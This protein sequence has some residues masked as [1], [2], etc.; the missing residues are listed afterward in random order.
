LL[1]ARPLISFRPMQ[2]TIATLAALA[3][4]TCA[5]SVLA[6]TWRAPTPTAAPSAQP[7][8]Y[9]PLPAPS[10]QIVWLRDG[11]TLRGYVVESV[12]NDHLTVRLD[13]GAFDR[14][15]WGDVVRVEPAVGAQPSAPSPVAAPPAGAVHV[16]LRANRRGAVL[17]RRVG[18]IG[19]LDDDGQT[20]GN[21]SLWERVCASPCE[22]DLAPGD[23]YRVAGEGAHPSR[24]F[25]LDPNRT[26]VR[27]DADVGS[28][29]ALSL[30]KG[31]VSTGIGLLALGT[32]M[33]VVPAPGGDDPSTD[34][35][36][37]TL[38]TVGYAAV[39]SGAV[40]TLVGLPLWIANATT[41][42]TDVGRTVGSL[43]AP[44]S[45][46]GIVVGARG[47]IF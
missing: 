21:A 28:E 45:P 26:D 32:V 17:E 22:T 47:V 38:H 31:F 20:S 19:L 27:L 16:V 37:S 14:I 30:G 1:R 36:W 29:H 12:P 25:T 44:A 41:V 40:L 34:S 24:S 42:K 11:T 10:E 46:S 7:V 2:R 18:S 33:L 9:A 35:A 8:S 3:A 15:A 43:P 6:Q 5:P 13:D 39:G 23:R 4:T